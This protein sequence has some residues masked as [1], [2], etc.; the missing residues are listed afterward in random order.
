[1]NNRHHTQP[2]AIAAVPQRGLREV[3]IP[4]SVLV[5]GLVLVLI[6]LQTGSGPV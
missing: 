2:K 4:A 3:L 5:F 1:M 6:T